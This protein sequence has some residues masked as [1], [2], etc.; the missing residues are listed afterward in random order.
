[1]RPVTFLFIFCFLSFSGFAQAPI[2]VADNTFK[3]KGFGE[4]VFYYGFAEGDQIILNFEELDNKELKEIEVIEL[5]GNS[6]FMDY[7]TKKVSDKTINIR[8]TGIYKIRFHNSAMSGRVCKLKLH[9]IPASSETL[10]FNTNV[11]WNTIYDTTY[12]TIKE[13]YL[14]KKQYVPKVIVPKQEAFVNSGSNAAFKGGKS[15]ITFPIVLP[16]NTVEW[17]Y[18]FS[19][20][21]KKEDVQNISSTFNLVGNLAKVM[22][23]TGGIGFAIGSLGNPPGADYCDV[24]LLDHNNSQAFLSKEN[25]QHFSLG[26]RKN[27]TSG[28]IKIEGSAEQVLHV[29]ILNP[30]SMHG[31]NVIFECVAIVLEEEWG[32]RDVQKYNVKKREEP[33]LKS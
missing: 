33:Y 32:I 18:Q 9:R 19:A 6:M 17:Y 20:M 14:I 2:E 26:H 16:K 21:R 7:K 24:Y 1:M 10:K 5:P 23:A 30:D 22:D 25:F 29:G 8:N 12:Y 3:V 13:K 4:Q 11:Y 27:I 31:I 28:I 15:R